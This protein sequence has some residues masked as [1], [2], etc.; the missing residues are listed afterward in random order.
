MTATEEQTD[1]PGRPAIRRPASGISIDPGRLTWFREARGWSRQELADAITRL[2]WKDDKGEPLTV[3]R[4]ALNKIENAT[5]KPKAQ[6]LRAIC[7]ALS[8]ADAPVRPRDLM[9][10]GPVLA[11]HSEA[12][13]RRARLD[14]NRELREFAKAHGI[15]YKNPETGRVYYCKAL[16]E[17]YA[18]HVLGNAA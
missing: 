4:D 2:G 9:P 17:M 8:E 3:S 11:P 16:R 12:D 6:S 1:R 5:R 15:E 18:Q 13:S 14:Y 7:A 10:G